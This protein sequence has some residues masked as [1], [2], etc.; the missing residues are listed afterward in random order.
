MADRIDTRPDGYLLA[1]GL[2]GP[3][4]ATAI[5]LFSGVGG[6]TLGFANAGIRVLA[7]SDVSATC[8]AT[9]AANLPRVPFVCADIRDLDATHF[10]RMLGLGPGDLDVLAGG[11]PCQG[12][13][14]IGKREAG[15]PR[16]ALF[17]HYLRLADALRPR[18][19]VME[20]V[21][22]MAT[23][24][25]GTPLRVLGSALRGIGYEP[26]CAEL[27]AAQYGV[28]QMRWRLVVIAW[29]G[30][31]APPVAGFPKP[32][33]GLAGIGDLVPNRP[34]SARET[35]GFL[36][37]RDAIGDLPAVAAG[38]TADTYSG[39][40]SRLYQQACRHGLTTELHNH[41]APKLAEANLRRICAL[42]P[43][44]DWRDLPED[45]LPEGMKAALR[46]DHTRR[47]SRMTWQGV[48][49]AIITRFRDP[50]SGEYIH[51]CQDRTISIREAAR[52]QSFPDWFR[53]LGTH[54]DQYEQ[55]GNAVPPLLA[56][57]IGRELVRVLSGD[58]SRAPSQVRARYHIPRMEQLSLAI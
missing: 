9:H 24:Q 26:H 54:T 41:Y 23:L 38:Q 57:A 29:R 30:D 46:K 47:Y 17:L 45:L 13:S 50:K 5:D 16:N 6:I 4:A 20:N 58:Y 48:P 43:G 3:P 35:E 22:G 40:P 28:P 52:I 42:A 7:C 8:Q 15:D 18:V 25:G 27:L 36:S 12:F 14:I 19:I 34:L 37:T 51:P 39:P 33:H 2:P 49:R 55:V 44:Q 31:V 10:S 11:P 53:F 56:R 32:D 21:P 1:S